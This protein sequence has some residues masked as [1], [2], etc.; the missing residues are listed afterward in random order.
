LDILLLFAIPIG[1]GVYFVRK[2]DLDG[3]LWWIGAIVYIISMIGHTLSD[4][5]LILPFSNSLNQSQIIPSI[6]VLFIIATMM[7]LSTGLWV[8]LLCYGMYHW[9]VKKARTWLDGVLIG[10]GLGGAGAIWIGFRD[11]YELVINIFFRIPNGAKG[12]TTE[13]LPPELQAQVNAFWSAPWYSTFNHSVQQL[14]MILI[15]ISLSILVLQALTRKRWFW[16][17]LAIGFQAL[18]VASNIILSNLVNQS[19]AYA[20]L[21]YFALVSV[22]LIFLL[23]TPDTSQDVSPQPGS[24]I[25]EPYRMK[26]PKS[27]EETLEALRK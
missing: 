15:L 18:V 14:F 23:R 4:T 27:V 9:W 17:L 11:I 12:S 7:G 16:I 2:F 22:I 24:L 8:G 21:G 1:F 6:T 5:Y 3:S 20:S 26:T 13:I 19:F 10:T 25:A